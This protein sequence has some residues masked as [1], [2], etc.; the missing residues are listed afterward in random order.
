VVTVALDVA[1]ELA[2][3]LFGIDVDRLSTRAVTAHITREIVRWAVARGWSP[4][5]EARVHTPAAL[6][7]DTR[8]GY[9]DVIV[10]RGDGM[11][12]LAIEI[13][14][15]DKPWSVDKLRH[16]ARA[17]MRAIWVRWGDEGWAGI[18]EDIDVIQ[19]PL[20]RRVGRRGTPDQLPLWP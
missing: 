20:I 4:H 1:D 14:S 17:G 11:P 6:G 2:I 18:Y 3:V 9:V 15:A 12:D 5:A 16:A 19:L 8:L 10:H 13:D 7:G